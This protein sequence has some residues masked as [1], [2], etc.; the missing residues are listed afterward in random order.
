MLMWTQCAV[1]VYA[2]NYVNFHKAFTCLL[3]DIGVS[4]FSTDDFCVLLLAWM[5]ATAEIYN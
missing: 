4:N 5:S 2:F 3:Y 1:V